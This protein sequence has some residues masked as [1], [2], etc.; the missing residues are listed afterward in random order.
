MKRTKNFLRKGTVA[1]TIAW[2]SLYPQ[3]AVAQTALDTAAVEAPAVAAD[4]SAR[5]G[6]VFSRLVDTL[7]AGITSRPVSKPLSWKSVSIP[8]ALI[9]IGTL[10]FTSDWVQEFNAFG[11]NFTNNDDNP[12]Q[13]TSLDDHTL[14]LPAVTVG[15]LHLAG[16]HGKNN[17]VDASVMVV[18]SQTL[19]YAGVIS[20]LKRFTAQRRPDGSDSLSFPSG[21][22][23]AAFVSAEFLR[24]EYKSVSPWI[25]AAGYGCAIL[26]GYLRMYNNKHWFSDVVA[27]AGVGI[28]STRVTYWLYPKIKNAVLRRVDPKGNAM[29]FPHYQNGSIGFTAV[30]RF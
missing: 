30:A 19:A 22:T 3:L 23:A 26:T 28:I 14:Y 16:V 27:G 13:R 29:I 6:P 25:G 17:I 1:F 4:S 7:A 20:P 5:R 21:H 12:D 15:A 11:K 24:Q 10:S 2:I 18:L 8:T 9:G